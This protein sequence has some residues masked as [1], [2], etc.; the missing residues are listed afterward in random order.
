MICTASWS[1]WRRVSR[2]WDVLRPLSKKITREFQRSWRRKE[3]ML[4]MH[5]RWRRSV[6]DF[7]SKFRSYSV[8][9]VR[10]RL[11]CS[12]QPWVVLAEATAWAL[13]SARSWTLTKMVAQVGRLMILQMDSKPKEQD[14]SNVRFPLSPTK[15]P[16]DLSVWYQFLK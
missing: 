3:K 4:R 2:S 16:Q 10:N 11:R 9:I 14:N 6:R 12:C 13:A 15:T 5:S 1:P 8:I 7:V